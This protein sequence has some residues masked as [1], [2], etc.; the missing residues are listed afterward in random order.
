MKPVLD[1]KNAIAIVNQY[2]LKHLYVSGSTAD[3]YRG[4]G[5][6]LRRLSN[7]AG[8]HNIIVD[9]YAAGTQI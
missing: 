5:N 1:G 7:D 3:L 2:D 8:S 6:T 9:G 4:D